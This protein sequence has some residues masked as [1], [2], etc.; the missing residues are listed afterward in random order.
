MTQES[1]LTKSI[2]ENSTPS[3]SQEKFEIIHTGIV[4]ESSIEDL[5]VKIKNFQDR[6][7]SKIKFISNSN[8]T[9]TIELTKERTPEELF[10]YRLSRVEK[11][12]LRWFK[13][14]IRRYSKVL[15]EKDSGI[16][17]YSKR[18]QKLMSNNQVVSKEMA[19]KFKRKQDRA[20][21]YRSKIN[22]MSEIIKNYHDYTYEEM[23]SFP[24]IFFNVGGSLK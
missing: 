16:T 14:G 15:K 7:Y 4:R 18:I 12:I 21:Y 5:T 11:T 19:D 2:R 9:Q 8:N 1:K 17:I 6:G 23:C 3:N 10:E 20:D 13:D 24:D 22:E